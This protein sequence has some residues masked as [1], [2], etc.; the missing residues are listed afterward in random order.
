MDEVH[1][2]L[3]R[4]PFR[5]ME[6]PGGRRMSVIMSNCGTTGWTSDQ[7]GYRYVD[8]DPLTGKPW[9]LLPETFRELAEGAAD[10]AG[11]PGFYPDV[12]LINGYRPGS[13]LSLHQDRDEQD[14][15]APIV[16][17]SLGLPAT[18]L[19]GGSRRNDPVLRIPLY[20][21]DILVWGGPSRYAFHGIAR[22]ASGHHPLTGPMRLNLTFRKAL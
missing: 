6:T 1:T 2:I 15:S 18:F 13:Q 14:G 4:A 12:C 8:R 22:L 10:C 16:S 20:H 11:F 9:P 21:G 7:R 5:C 19:F 3:S 17:I